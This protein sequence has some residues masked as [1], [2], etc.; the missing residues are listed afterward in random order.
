MPFGLTM[1]ESYSHSPTSLLLSSTVWPARSAVMVQA[2]SAT[3]F[4]TGCLTT[5]RTRSPA[6]AHLGE[7]GKLTE[8]E[9]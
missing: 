1:L 9:H 5:S 3:Y 8:E 6:L 2:H 7:D 4:I